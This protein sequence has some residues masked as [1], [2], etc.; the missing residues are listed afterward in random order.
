MKRYPFAGRAAGR[1]VGRVAGS[2]V[3]FLAKPCKT[4]PPSGWQQVSVNSCRASPKI[5]HNYQHDAG[6]AVTTLR[7][8]ANTMPTRCPHDAHTMPTRCPHDAHRMPTGFPHDAPLGSIWKIFTPWG[9]TPLPPQRAMYAYVF[10]L[11]HIY[12]YLYSQAC[13]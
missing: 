5:A 13:A 6:L 7:P 2:V 1:A 4:I 8:N 11:P 10:I 3:S 12:T 9:V